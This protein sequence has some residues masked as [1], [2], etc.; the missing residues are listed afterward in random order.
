MSVRFLVRVFAI[1]IAL[2]GMKAQT[3]FAQVPVT[4]TSDFPSM[5]H[6][7]EIIAQWTNQLQLMRNQ[8]DTMRQQYQSI[9]GTYGR[10][11]IGLSASINSSS[12]VPGSWQEIVAQQQSGAFGTSQKNAELL[13]KTMPQELFRQ[14]Q[15]Q[16]AASYK[17]STDSVRAAI[18][19]G[20]LLFAQVQTNLNNLAVMAGQIDA[21]ANTKDAADLQN[22]ITTE[23]AMLQTAMAKLNVMNLNLQAN[24]LNQQNQATAINQQRYKRSGP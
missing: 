14:P 6:Q 10:G 16:G 23:N 12:V 3:A 21:T 17:L 7:T 11:S 15:G 20:D 5:V 22:R 1:S 4:I 18:S 9:T 24:M 13:I 19:G 8:Y 2:S